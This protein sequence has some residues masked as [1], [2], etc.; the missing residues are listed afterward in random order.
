MF[1]ID[2]FIHDPINS[3]LARQTLQDLNTSIEGAIGSGPD[4]YTR[5]HLNDAHTRIHK[6]L[7]ATYTYNA[8]QAS[9]KT[10]SS[11]L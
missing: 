9:V 6:A 5:A 3:L 2:V 8:Q 4:A 1:G 7:D 11:A 10:S